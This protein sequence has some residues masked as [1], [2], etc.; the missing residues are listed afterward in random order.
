MRPPTAY[1]LKMGQKICQ[2]LFPTG[3][4]VWYVADGFVEIFSYDD[5][6]DGYGGTTPL[7]S[8][9]I[10]QYVRDQKINKLL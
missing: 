7:A 4:V 8:I 3:T 1:E 9:N 2:E 5:L 6:E 10:I